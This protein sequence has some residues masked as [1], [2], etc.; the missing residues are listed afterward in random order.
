MALTID[1]IKA[2]DALKELTDDQLSALVTLST[3]D[4]QETINA[5]IGQIYGD[6]DRDI[7]T[8]S[9]VQKKD[10]EKTYDYAKRVIGSLKEKAGGSKELQAKIDEQ[11]SV[12]SDLEKKIKDGASDEAI[13]KKLAD[14]ETKLGNLQEQYDKDKTTWESTQKEMEAKV[15]NV[16]VDVAFEKAVAGLKFKAG[17]SEDIKNV[18]LDN[19]KK[20]IL[21]ELT[22]DW[23]EADGKK[24]LIFRDKDGRIKTNP[25]NLQNAITAEELVRSKLGD[26]LDTGRTQTGTGSKG[27][28]GPGAPGGDGAT[29][30]L[31]SIKTQVAADDAIAAD[32][33]SRGFTRGTTEFAEKFSEIRE[34]N[35]VS[36]LPVR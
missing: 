6:L 25:N 8:S 34:E 33:M 11:T 18:L 1:K 27:T 4:E 16:Q 20:S 32:L 2:Q 9:E 10:G 15:A 26:A 7:L 28:E 21:N 31:A 17:F 35:K 13:K 23:E 29:L 24:N 3:N 22:P 14:A 19:A 5:R 12:I 36:E 30:D